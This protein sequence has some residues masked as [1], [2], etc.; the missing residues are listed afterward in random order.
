MANMSIMVMPDRG[1]L[2]TMDVIP[3]WTGEYVLKN[4][5]TGDVLS[6]H[7]NCKHVYWSSSES[8][9]TW[10]HFTFDEH[11]RLVSSHDTCVWYDE[12]S[13]QMWQYPKANDDME[14]SLYLSGDP[15]PH[16]EPH[17]FGNLP[18]SRYKKHLKIVNEVEKLIEPP[19]RGRKPM[20]DEEKS[21]KNVMKTLGQD[22]GQVEEDA[23]KAF[24]KEQR[25]DIKKENPDMKLQEQK[26]FL[27][28]LWD[29]LDD[30]MK[31]D[32]VKL[33]T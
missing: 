8:P 18:E 26:K 9:W 29:N 31:L 33:S 2:F 1:S 12:E 30:N 24:C 6:A 28:N 19:K 22:P 10:E 3:V 25:S 4:T 16:E 7:D 11:K 5:T 14:R 23:Y 32:Y 15:P 21:K 27:K 17:G 13:E 20:S